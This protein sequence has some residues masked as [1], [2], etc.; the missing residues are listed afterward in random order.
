MDMDKTF[1]Q[2]AGIEA[3]MAAALI[4]PL[5]QLL[6]WCANTAIAPDKLLAVGEACRSLLDSLRSDQY[7]AKIG[8]AAFGSRTL[9]YRHYPRGVFIV[10]LNSPVNDEV[11]A[12]L[13]NQVDPLL[14]E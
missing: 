6:G 5:N 8:S 10:Y 2:I 14:A 9:V 3:V 13:W 12:W 11:L 1:E 4:S 7:E